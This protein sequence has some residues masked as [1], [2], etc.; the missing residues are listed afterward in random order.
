MISLPTTYLATVAL[1]AV[2]LSILVACVLTVIR[3]PSRRSFAAIAG[4][5]AMGVLPWFT[6][7]RPEQSERTSSVEVLPQT[8]SPTLPAWTVVTLSAPEVRDTVPQDMAAKA[9]T[10]FAIPEPVEAVVSVWC[11]GTGARLVLLA[12]A[13]FRTVFWRRSL[14][15]MDNEAWERLA[16]VSS[17]LPD[18]SRFLLSDTTTSPCVTGF[19]R[20]RIV[21]PDFLLADGAE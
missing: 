12:G 1:H 7:L 3:Q 5:L 8:I 4:L 9:P 15:P 10:A 16:A 19:F 2:V 6:A 21:L 14:L 13:L 17:D 11:I 20:T 18:R